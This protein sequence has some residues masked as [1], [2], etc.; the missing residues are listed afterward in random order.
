MKTTTLMTASL[1]AV[2]GLGSVAPAFAQVDRAERREDRLERREDRRERREDYRER[3]EDRAER[4]EDMRERRE[5]Y[6]ERLEDRRQ[7]QGSRYVAPNHGYNAPRYVYNQPRY[8]YS[9]PVY[10]RYYRGGYLPYQY[11]QP[12]YYVGN[13]QAVHGLYAPP[14]G[15]QWVQVG[16]DY[17][18]IALATG[19]IANL[20]TM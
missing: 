19:L 1:A 20:L 11:R 9:Q 8:V 14:Y 15:Y 10:P 2:L 6:R 4:R 3:L 16:N 13:W 18:L 5:D 17:L 7:W 12:T